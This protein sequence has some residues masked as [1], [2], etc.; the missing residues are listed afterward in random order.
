MNIKR[1]APFIVVSALSV[2]SPALAQSDRDTHFDGPY[3]SGTIGMAA[4]NNDHGDTLVFDTD[5]DGHY[6]DTPTDAGGAS[7]IA[8]FCHGSAGGATPDAGC[9][10]DNNR[11]EY[12]GRIGY[13][14]RMGNNFVVGGLIEASKSNARDY[15]SGYT[16]APDAYQLGRKMD[17]AVS[18][19]ARA[20]YTPGGGALFY[21]TGGASYGKIKHSFRTTNTANGFAEVNDGDHVWG[22]Q[23]GG[24]GEV[25]LTNNISLGLEYL[26]NR[27]NDDKYRVAVS[28]GTAPAGNPFGTGTSIR[29]SDTDFSYHSLRATV[30]YQF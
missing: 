10:P 15:T 14:K 26:Y 2:A 20:G 16:T 24:G 27:Y 9:G 18:L 28:Q 5:G 29:P 11:I 23:A 3:V 6:N 12:S 19:R 22:W 25:M 13:D 8:G 30:S 4:Q 7:A 1:A 17:Y 21:V